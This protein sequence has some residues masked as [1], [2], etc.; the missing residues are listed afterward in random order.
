MRRQRNQPRQEEEREPGTDPDARFCGPGTEWHAA[1]RV[2]VASYHK[3]VAE[4][5]G[6]GTGAHAGPQNFEC[7]RLDTAC[8]DHDGEDDEEEL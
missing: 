1:T 8:D 2:C 3:A 5:A 4:C 6:S 7:K